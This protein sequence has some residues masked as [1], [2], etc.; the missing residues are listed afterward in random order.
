MSVLNT[1]VSGGGGSIE[2]VNANISSGKGVT[3][4]I[5]SD[6]QDAFV[7]YDGNFSV[8]K[9]SLVYIINDLGSFNVSGGAEPINNNVYFV[10]DDFSVNGA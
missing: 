8:L 3:S 5:Y 6:G 2:T 9:Y 4:F 1:S 7:A 10:T